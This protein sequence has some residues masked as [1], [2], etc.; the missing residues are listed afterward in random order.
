MKTTEFWSFIKMHQTNGTVCFKI[1]IERKEKKQQKYN[2]KC[3]CENS[4]PLIEK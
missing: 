4:L 3:D 1:P 2:I